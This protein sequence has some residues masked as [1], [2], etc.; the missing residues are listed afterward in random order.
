MEISG[1]GVVI[2]GGKRI[3]AD[4]AKALA[5]RGADVA[6]VFNR[7]RHEADATAAAIAGMGRRAFVLSADLTVPASCRQVIDEA[8]TALGRLDVLVNMA[9]VYESKSLDELAVEDWDRGIDVDLRATYLCTQA[10]IPCIRRQ[11]GGR[12]INFTDWIAASGRPRY[13]GYVP[14]YVAKMGVIGLTQALALELATDQILVNAVAPG[15]ILAP[16][17]TSEDELRAVER[18]TPLGRWGGP[19]EISKAVVFLIETDFVTGETI[20]VDGGRHLK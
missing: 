1:R 19:A 6:L 3:G 18:A 13:T 15:P 16:A 14:Y 8:A 20:R 7:S 5:A 4:V 17:G 10:A 11:G 12:V 2:T 9:S